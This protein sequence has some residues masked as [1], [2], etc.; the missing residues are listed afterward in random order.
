MTRLAA[1]LLILLQGSGLMAP[2]ICAHVDAFDQPMC[3]HVGAVTGHDSVSVPDACDDCGMPNCQNMLTCTA[4]GTAVTS[5][6]DS[7]LLG[8]AVVA[9]DPTTI[10]T[11]HSRHPAPSLPPPKV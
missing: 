3:E 1:T 5:H 2:A 7:S 8:S 6:A 10:A 11:A 4:A 9:R